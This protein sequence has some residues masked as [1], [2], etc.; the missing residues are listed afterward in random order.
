MNNT[1][2][3]TEV[4]TGALDL[5]I[6]LSKSEAAQLISRLASYVADDN[7]PTV[8]M[9]IQTYYGFDHRNGAIGIRTPFVVI[10]DQLGRNLHADLMWSA[11]QGEVFYS[12]VEDPS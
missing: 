12:A 7:Y 11:A 10:Y 3:E 4:K 9:R 2:T 6:S 1:L 8:D 5:M